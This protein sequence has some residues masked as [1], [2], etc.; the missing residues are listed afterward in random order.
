VFHVP[1]RSKYIFVASLTRLRGSDASNVHD[2]EPAEY[3]LEFSD[4][5]AEAAHKAKLR[6]RCVCFVRW[7]LMRILNTWDRR[8]TSRAP[9]VPASPAHVRDQDLDASYGWNPYAEHGAYD[10][11]LDYGAGPARPKPQPYD[12]P[13]SDAYNQPDA[14]PG[15]ATSLPIP[16]PPRPERASPG[17]AAGQTDYGSQGRNSQRAHHH[18]H[19]ERG[20]GRGHMR[21]RGRGRGRGGAREGH[22][23][24]LHRTEDHGATHR[25]TTPLS[26]TSSLMAPAT[27]QY[28]GA[29]EY[30]S[31]SPQL[32][33]QLGFVQ[34]YP[35]VQHQNQR[36]FTSPQQHSVQ[37][38]INPRFAAQ[39]GL[40]LEMMQH[41]PPGQQYST[42]SQYET[43]TTPV[44]EGGWDG[45]WNQG[46]GTGSNTSG[47]HHPHVKKEPDHDS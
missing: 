22:P 38:H 9:S 6:D 20:R 40:G 24:P 17:K 29:S 12:D 30:A 8:H 4:D 1:A 7:S 37:P 18:H 10:M 42:Y 15:T 11:D 47:E 45:Q 31:F 33:S 2:E 44:Y 39:F 14:K 41:H 13:Y 27:G 28:Y 34:P 16:P 19:R 35:P 23:L 21:G 43:P 32:P 46:Y 5:E 36:Q 25:P 26:P 3:E